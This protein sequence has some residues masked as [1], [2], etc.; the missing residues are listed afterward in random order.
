MQSFKAIAYLTM[1]IA[2]I[3]LSLLLGKAFGAIG[4]YVSS[5]RWQNIL[6]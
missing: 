4:V 3:I 5:N 1:S 2:N 6:I